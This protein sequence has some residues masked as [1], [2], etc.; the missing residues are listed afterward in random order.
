MFVLAVCCAGALSALVPLSWRAVA[1]ARPELLIHRTQ[2]TRM[3][4][5]GFEA[6]TTEEELGGAILNEDARVTVTYSSGAQGRT[7][8]VRRTTRPTVEERW[9]QQS[10][11]LLRED[12]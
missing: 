7:R 11:G 5:E 12:E 9:R 2:L 3:V 4:A 1:T 6:A 10:A 8:R